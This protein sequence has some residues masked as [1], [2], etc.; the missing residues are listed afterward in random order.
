MQSDTAH[1]VLPEVESQNG[2]EELVR[3]LRVDGRG[4]H[5]DGDG[6]WSEGFEYIP[7]TS[8]LNDGSM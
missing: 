8:T 2:I 6:L 3:R 1:G 5:G 7:S 4:C